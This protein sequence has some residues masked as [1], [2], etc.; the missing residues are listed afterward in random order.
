MNSYGIYVDLSRLL[1]NQERS[2]VFDAVDAVVP[3]SG[4]V[5]VQRGT[6]DE[7]YFCIDAASETEAKA[8]TDQ[9]M[10]RI[11]DRAGLDVSF[12]IGC[13]S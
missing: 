11:T 5:G 7:I 10:R 13:I 9:Y 6:T 8:I 1:S 3:G 2:E 4:C 12:S